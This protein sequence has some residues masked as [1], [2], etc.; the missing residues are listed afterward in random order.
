MPPFHRRAHAT[1]LA[2][3]ATASRNRGAEPFLATLRTNALETTNQDG[4]VLTVRHTLLAGNLA[5]GGD[6]GPGG[7]GGDGLGG[8]LYVS[9]TTV[10]VEHTHITA[11]QAVGGSGGEGGHDGQGV[12]GG[13]SIAAGSVCI[14][15]TKIKDNEAS[16]SD[17][18]IFGP[19]TLC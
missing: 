5:R 1:P 13:V 18:D 9:G 8:G 16:T 4:A 15:E 11:N 7:N 17:N 6:G 12:V 10:Q 3:K 19:Y 14:K 2:H